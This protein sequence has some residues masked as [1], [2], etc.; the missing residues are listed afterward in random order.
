MATSNIHPADTAY[1]VLEHFHPEDETAR[2]RA[3]IVLV[4]GLGGHY[5]KSW[6]AA[7][8]CAWPWHLLP[9]KV[10]D[11]RVRSFR[12]TTTIYGTTSKAGIRAHA[13]DL[14]SKL[15]DDRE[16]D[17][18]AM[19]R[20]IIFVGHSL[21]GIIIKQAIRLARDKQ[22][23][24]SLWEASR[25]IASRE[26]FFATPQ[27]GMD[28][29][30]WDFFAECVLRRNAPEKDVDPTETMVNDI[31]LNSEMMYRIS[32]DFKAVQKNLAFV[33]FVEEVPMDGAKQVLVTEAQGLIHDIERERHSFTSG[34]H[35]EL[36]KF[37]HNEGDRFR[38]VWS[39]VEWL[40][41][42]MPKP[43]DRLSLQ[44]RK[45]LYSLCPEEFHR[46]FL[47]RESTEGTCTWIAQRPEF[48]DWL[49]G[50]PGR[51][52]L[53][54]SSQPG[55]GKSFLAKHIIAAMSSTPHEAIY[56]FMS[57]STPGR[58][59]LQALMRAT[60]HQ[61]LRLEPEIIRDLLPKVS[62]SLH[63]GSKMWAQGLLATHW[64]E[65]MAKVAARHSLAFVVDGL[66]ELRDE[67]RTGFLTCIRQFE[68][69][70]EELKPEKHKSDS[71]TRPKSSKFRILILSRKASDLGTQL[72]VC[73]FNQ[74]AVTPEDTAEDF[75]KIV[76][77]S[78]RKL[79]DFLKKPDQSFT[80]D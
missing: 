8:G 29:A 59:N 37:G 2:V 48:R 79:W 14:L 23:F 51:H 4:A 30:A 25:G 6:E 26:M 5:I 18:A 60:L 44:E 39:G 24:K 56:C 10:H 16:E 58:G 72:S 78:L 73:G 45:A 70:L 38:P 55:G 68:K 74:Y 17:E 32:Q 71:D 27:W 64:P 1:S 52:K 50:I 36:C 54:V 66:D 20:P 28:E 63:L 61:A 77:I 80:S 9:S 67:C 35:L 11:I 34:D 13:T 75:K 15:Y 3:D 65:T 47:N 42:Q 46:Y 12:Y 22:K 40:I 62:Q 43:I 53:C 31:K 49:D 21:G 33:S 7:D 76:R 19:I 41:S 69:N 57:N